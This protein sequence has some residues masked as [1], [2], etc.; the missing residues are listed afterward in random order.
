VTPNRLEASLKSNKRE[1][2]LGEASSALAMELDGSLK[3]FS[4]SHLE[5]LPHTSPSSKEL[6]IRSRRE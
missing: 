4:I 1:S 2:M 6:R 5:S 3:S